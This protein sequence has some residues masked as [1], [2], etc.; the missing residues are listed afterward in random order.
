MDTGNYIVPL[1]HFC[2]P[3]TNTGFSQAA[4]Q[5]D[6]C[7]VGRRHDPGRVQVFGRNSRHLICN[8]VVTVGL[9]ACRIMRAYD[10]S[11]HANMARRRGDK[12]MNR[13][14]A[15]TLCAF[16]I[17]LT[18]ITNASQASRNP[19]P[20]RYA[21]RQQRPSQHRVARLERRIARLERENARLRRRLAQSGSRAIQINSE[22]ARQSLRLMQARQGLERKIQTEQEKFSS[23]TD[24]GW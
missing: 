13:Q 14:V 3:G 16:L 2:G 22:L 1:P 15:V 11:W 10:L 5:S 12:R 21:S 23:A 6:F 24:H 9:S 17:G 4:G 18:T 8:D 7:L 19:L 20:H